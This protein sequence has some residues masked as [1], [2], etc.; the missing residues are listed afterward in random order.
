VPVNVGDA[1]FALRFNA[2]CVAVDTGLFASLVLSTFPN[3]KLVLGQDGNLFTITGAT[4]INAVNV[5]NWQAGSTIA[6]IF[7]GAPLVK[8]NTAGGAGTATML[9]AGRTDFQAAAGD[10]LELQYDGT[11]W[12]ETAR[13]LAASAPNVNIYNSDGTVLT[14]RV[15]TLGANTLTFTANTLAGDPAISITSTSTAAASNLQKGLNIDLSGANATGSQ[16]TYGLYVS[17][18]HS[19]TTPVNHGVYST[20]TNG[21][22]SSAA[23]KAAVTTQLG[24]DVVGTSG[25]GVQVSV[26]SGKAYYGAVTG[27]NVVADFLK[28][29]ATT[30]SV[31]PV[32]NITSYS[33][34]TA[35]AGFGTSIDMYTEADNNSN[36]LSARLQSVVSDAAAATFTSNF[37][38]LVSKSAATTKTFGVE[39]AG[40]VTVYTARF[41]QTQGV[42][43]ASVAGAIAV[44]SDGNTFELTGTNAVTLISNA[45][46][47]NG[48]EITLVFTS[49]ATLTD[50]TANSGTD[51][52]MELAGGANFTGSADDVVVLVLSEMG[53]TQRWRE[54][55]RSVN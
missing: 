44:G 21:T 26:T 7:T 1:K 33:N 19:G 18:T 55:S 20:L 50:G 49:T 28:G 29:G 4:Q 54:K 25:T 24:V 9:L 15:A 2:V 32:Q 30:N 43:V 10:Y 14:D 12:Y 39:G 53:G 34:G 3:P 36:P 22:S 38:V 27:A 40:Y 23:F 6:W 13:A 47:Q 5:T 16:T 11:N 46:W 8:N 35:A 42:D 52:G 41:R 17:N 45:G 48:S 51:I 37:E 31:L